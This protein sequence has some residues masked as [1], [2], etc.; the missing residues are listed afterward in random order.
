MLNKNWLEKYESK[1]EL[2]RCKLDLE[3]YFTEKQIENATIDTLEIGKV[4]FPT[5]KILVCDPLI[6][7]KM[8]CHIYRPY[9]KENTL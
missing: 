9:R 7:L 6:E 4:N 2:L 3:A 5:G 1:K 8:L